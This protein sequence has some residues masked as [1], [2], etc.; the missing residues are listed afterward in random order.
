MKTNTFLLLVILL[1]TVKS[2]L[3]PLVALAS[4][5]SD[6][7]HFTNNLRESQ[8]NKDIKLQSVLSTIFTQMQMKNTDSIK[9][10]L[11]AFFKKIDENIT[12]LNKK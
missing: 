8:M 11:L 5:A 7:D 6:I 2:D 1:I 10:E 3:S 4:K 12:T 9:Q